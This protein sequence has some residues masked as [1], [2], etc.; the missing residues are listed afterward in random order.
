MTD[1]F[2]LDITITITREELSDYVQYYN[3]TGE[4]S[5]VLL[6]KIDDKKTELYAELLKKRIISY[7]TDKFFPDFNPFNTILY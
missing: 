3:E 1:D 4:I 6:K 5:P 7:C 2:T